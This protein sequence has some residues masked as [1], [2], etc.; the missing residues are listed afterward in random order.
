MRL[1]QITRRGDLSIADHLAQIHTW[2]DREDIRAR[3]VR[4]ERV[5]AGR[6]SFRAEFDRPDD[7]ERFR[8]A[9]GQ[10]H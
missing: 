7:A 6:I 4:A 10:S 5:F 2:L 3:S 9:F 8:D 1:I